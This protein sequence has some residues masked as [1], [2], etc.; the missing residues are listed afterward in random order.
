MHLWQSVRKG[1]IAHLPHSLV[2]YRT[3]Q[4]SNWY[5]KAN[6]EMLLASETVWSRF[7]VYVSVSLLRPT[8][9]KHCFCVKQIPPLTN[10][11]PPSEKKNAESASHREPRTLL[12]GQTYFSTL[13]GCHFRA[14]QCFHILALTSSSTKMHQS[15]FHPLLSGWV[16][17][18]ASHL[19]L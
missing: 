8:V 10:G 9:M 11:W 15:H 2:N 18:T 5:A 19:L 1:W 3:Q 14:S 4:H 16:P 7:Q 17:L 12:K 6:N 13:N